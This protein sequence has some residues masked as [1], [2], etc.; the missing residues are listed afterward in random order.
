VTAIRVEEIPAAIP[1]AAQ[2]RPGR[3]LLRVLREDRLAAVGFFLVALLVFAAA[4]GRMVAPD[5]E[6]GRGVTD[7][8]AI[9]MA[10]GAA[11]WFGTDDLGRDIFSRILFGAR[12]AL[13]ISVLVV[14][15]AIAIGVPIGA[16]AGYRGGR[17][18]ELL[19]RITDLFL[20]FPPLL[21]AMVIVAAMGPSLTHAGYALAIAWWPW[22]ARI[23]RGVAQS[24][25]DRPFVEAA[26]VMGVRDSVILRRHIVRNALSPILVQATVDIGTVILAAGS[27]AFIGLGAQAPTADWGLMVSEGRITILTSWW[28]STF[29]GAAIFLAVLGFNLVGDALRDVL[30]PR[31]APR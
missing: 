20:A 29:P 21:L 8:D 27:L 7:V 15:L 1:V 2:A 24:L 12:P 28:I 9:G 16:V 13:L 14:M 11:H 10:P 4:F 26:R 23:V 6:A 17:L 30:D 19:M 18:D 3:A 5:P 25:R 31:T 22:Y